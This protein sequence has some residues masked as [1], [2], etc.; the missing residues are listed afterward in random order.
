MTVGVLPAETGVMAGEPRPETG[1]PRHRRRRVLAVATAMVLFGSGLAYLWHDEAGADHQFA[2]THWSLNAT[3]HQ[4][5]VVRAEL[6]AARRDLDAVDRQ[7]QQTSAQLASDTSALQSAQVALS[8][9]QGHVVQQG[10]SINNLQ[11]CLGGVEQALN[12]LS[13]GDQGSA[14]AALNAVSAGC[15][16][17]V[18]SNV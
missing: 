14:I 5:A 15:Q 16:S 10:I 12:A 13:V 9:A 6:E 8:N 4:L 18:V 7:L 1:R 17:A 3:R 2:V 11:V